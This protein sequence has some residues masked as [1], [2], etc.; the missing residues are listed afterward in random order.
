MSHKI[1]TIVQECLKYRGYSDSEA[2]HF[3]KVLK[4]SNAPG[5]APVRK[6]NSQF[7]ILAGITESTQ[8][9]CY[10]LENLWI[11]NR[12]PFRYHKMQFYGL[13]FGVE[14]KQVMLF[15]SRNEAVNFA[16]T[17][18]RS[19][20]WPVKPPRYKVVEIGVKIIKTHEFVDTELDT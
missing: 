3:I 12:S 5:I 10:I 7:C 6:Q 2:N 1:E 15:E 11:G 14:I 8:G 20:W 9:E 4:K 18:K 16:E 13:G 17:W 19:S